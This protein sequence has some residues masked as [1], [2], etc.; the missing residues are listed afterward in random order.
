MEKIERHAFDS[1]TI[2]SVYVH[3]V[4]FILST[5]DPL[6]SPT[7][8]VL[9]VPKGTRDIF[10]TREGWK[11]INDV[12]EGTFEPTWSVSDYLPGSSSLDSDGQSI[13]QAGVTYK[14]YNL[15]GYPALINFCI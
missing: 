3:C 4:P 8:Q 2:D 14:L 7:N 6:G 5:T 13:T 1:N 12:I 10:S 11:Q 15:A 9:I